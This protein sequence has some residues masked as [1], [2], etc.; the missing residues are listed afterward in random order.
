VRAASVAL[1]VLH[2]K[3]AVAR[4]NAGHPPNV[5]PV[6][7]TGTKVSTNVAIDPVE[8]RE[9]DGKGALRGTRSSR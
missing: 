7:A 6:L 1:D 5:I 4:A 9:D 2:D 3:T 8:K